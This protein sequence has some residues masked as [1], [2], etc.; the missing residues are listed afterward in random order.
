[1][2]E[3]QSRTR[4]NDQ[5]RL[6]RRIHC[7]TV[8]K[9]LKCFCL[10]TQLVVWHMYVHSRYDTF[11]KE[12][13]TLWRHD[14]T[15]TSC[16]ITLFKKDPLQCS[17]RKNIQAKMQG[18]VSQKSSSLLVQEGLYEINRQGENNGWILF[19]WNGAECLQVAELKRGRRFVHDVSRLLEC[20]RRLVLALR[21]YH[22]QMEQ[23]WQ[24]KENKSRPVVGRLALCCV[25][26]TKDEL[27][28]PWR[29][30]T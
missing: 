29:G 19:G 30:E 25:A 14:V 15:S 12:Y 22:L 26:T 16:T 2:E 20:A 23:P 3:A 7:C 10:S 21:R 28:V 9:D 4:G 11:Q 13:P 18:S 17:L 6:R 5:W 1:M 24:C 27:L 8:W